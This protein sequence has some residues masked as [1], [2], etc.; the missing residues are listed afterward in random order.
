ME[1]FLPLQYPIV[2][3]Q[4]AC[5]GCPQ[6]LQLCKHRFLQDTT[7]LTIL[8]SGVESKKVDTSNNMCPFL[9]T[10]SRTL[11]LG[12]FWCSD[13]LIFT[14]YIFHASN[15]NIHYCR[16]HLRLYRFTGFGTR[17]RWFIRIRLR[18]WFRTR[19]FLQRRHSQLYWFGSRLHVRRGTRNVRERTRP[20]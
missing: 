5:H 17:Y 20:E 10:L 12:F 11:F 14:R 8:C 7:V 3:S 1:M 18:R 19:F 15:R 6:I 2:P 4:P 16:L 13:F 9:L